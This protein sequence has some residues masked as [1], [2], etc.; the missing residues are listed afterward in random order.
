MTASEKIIKSSPDR[1]YPYHIVGIIEKQLEKYLADYR[2]IPG[3]LS[4]PVKYCIMNGGKRFRPVLCVITA[5]GLGCEPAG[6]MPTACAIEFIHSYSL[7]HDDLPAIDDDDLRRGKP[8][9]HKRFGEAAAILAGDALFAEAFNLILKYQR[10][11]SEKKVRVLSE[12][13]A[14]SG[15]SGMVAGQIV[16]ISSASKKISKKTLEHMHINKTARL[17][18]ASIVSSAILC[19][20]EEGTIDGLRKYGLNIGLTFQI[21]DDII[22]II[23]SSSISGKTQGKDK[24]Q[25]KNTYPFL[26]GLD[27][28]R[29]IAEEKIDA[30]LDAIKG[31]QMDPGLLEDIARFIL[32]RKA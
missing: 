15:A 25:S 12:I 11:S 30:A 9:C 29:K 22:D 6:I 14:A 28:S 3:E 2:D 16:D 31:L 24:V 27:K 1:L 4:E 19:G 20:A 21:T 7:T 17:I 32:L 8:S 5:I 23:S 26:W 13:A 18:S 10:C